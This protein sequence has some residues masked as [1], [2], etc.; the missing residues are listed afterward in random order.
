MKS[1][2]L[3]GYPIPF[4]DLNLLLYGKMDP[5][6]VD[7]SPEKLKEAFEAAMPKLRSGTVGKAIIISTV[8]DKNNWFKKIWEDGNT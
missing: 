8:N 3:K 1:K 6:S 4:T 2:K 7:M 5:D